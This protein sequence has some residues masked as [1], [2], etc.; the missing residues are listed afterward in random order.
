M[1]LLWFC[2]RRPTKFS[3]SSMS[4]DCTV[5]LFL[6]VKLPPQVLYQVLYGKSYFSSNF[7]K[8]SCA[9]GFI[10]GQLHFWTAEAAMV[11]F[12][13][14]SIASIFSSFGEDFSYFGE[15]LIDCIMPWFTQFEIIILITW[16][17]Y[18]GATAVKKDVIVLLDTANSMGGQ[19]PG[20]LLVTAAI[21]KLSASL[22][23]VTE[24]LDTLAY[25]DRVTVITFTSSGANIVLSPVSNSAWLH[26]F[27][28]TLFRSLC[29]L[30]RNSRFDPF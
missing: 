3:G 12:V 19:L 5:E 1:G 6:I 27:L 16:Y 8:L 20:D 15:L 9:T 14:N 22:S 7:W 25:G 18:I 26:Q 24:L 29:T 28:T 11:S 21:S 10:T 2:G 30:Y 23:I 13:T 4:S 17:R